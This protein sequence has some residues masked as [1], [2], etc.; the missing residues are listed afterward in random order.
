VLAASAWLIASRPTP[1]KTVRPERGELV[2]EVFGT[3]TLESKVVVDVSS[4][5]IGKVIE[6][7][8]DQGDTVTAGQILARLGRSRI[9]S[10]AL[11]VQEGKTGVF[12][13][14]DARAR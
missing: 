10:A 2:A 5:I 12:A 8:V 7:L 6:V 1:V 3:G 14:V 13:I 9:P 11:V 4:K